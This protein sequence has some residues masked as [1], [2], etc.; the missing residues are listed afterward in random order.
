MF[1]PQRFW[2]E[3]LC[4]VLSV[5]VARYGNLNRLP[6][7]AEGCLHISKGNAVLLTQ[8]ELFQFHGEPLPHQRWRGE[9]PLA[10][11]FNGL[12]RPL[13]LAPSRPQ[14][15]DPV[16]GRRWCDESGHISGLPVY[17][18]HRRYGWDLGW[19]WQPPEENNVKT[20]RPISRMYRMQNVAHR[21]ASF[22][23][24]RNQCNFA[25]CHPQRSIRFILFLNIPEQSENLSFFFR[26][27]TNNPTIYENRWRSL[28]MSACM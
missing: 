16:F 6:S 1:H 7:G 24:V 8:R 4:P 2:F 20:A 23:W 12:A 10:A 18:Q 21:V 26:K 28:K 15:G 17:G 9:L 22:A 25:L 13:E 27:S 19:L 5:R 14:D 11:N 3:Q